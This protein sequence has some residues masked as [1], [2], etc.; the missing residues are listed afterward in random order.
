MRE[1]TSPALIIAKA[2]LFILLGTLAG[3][4]LVARDPSLATAALVAVT[5][6]AFAR[7]YFFAF[8]VIEKYIDP[9]YRFAGLV[10]ALRWLVARRRRHTPKP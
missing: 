4:L 1:I 3:A 6:W 2:A 5:V 9:D 10:S 7:A 8:T